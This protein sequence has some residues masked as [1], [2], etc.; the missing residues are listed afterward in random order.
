MIE[1]P[2]AVNWSTLKYMR[3]SPKHYRHALAT[4]RTDSD[5]LKLGRLVH[6]MVYEPQHVDDRYV[7]EPKFNRTMKDETAIARG[8]DGGREAAEAFAIA[9]VMHDVVPPVLWD[10]ALAM[11]AAIHDDPL[12]GPMV[13]GGYVE[14]QI[15]W[16]D[17]ATGV[18]CR[19]RV[20][21]VNGR[22]SD[23]KT[24]RVIEPR[25]F[26]A[27]AARYGYHAQV[28]Y[29][30]DGL[31]ANGIVLEDVPAIPAVEN[32]APYDVAVYTLPPDVIAAGRALYRSCLDRLVECRAK[33]EWPGVSPGYTPLVLPAWAVHAEDE[34]ITFGGEAMF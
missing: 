9:H 2:D 20:D 34:E 25:Q 16:I 32:E 24:T 31:A 5:A 6:C 12:A 28:A 13:R 10:K 11:S 17:E 15:T 21:H 22:L 8:L 18:E 29:Y 3:V 23:L 1:R 30:L 14:Q 19:G 7:R 26:A 4:P 27:A 33:D